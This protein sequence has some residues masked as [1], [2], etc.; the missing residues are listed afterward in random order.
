MCLHAE[1]QC[2]CIAERH[3]DIKKMPQKSF[4]FEKKWSRKNEGVPCGLGVGEEGKEEGECWCGY[5][6]MIAITTNKKGI[7][8]R[9]TR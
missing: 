6:C 5:E 3:I 2:G 7:N 9:H 8:E 4:C 1:G